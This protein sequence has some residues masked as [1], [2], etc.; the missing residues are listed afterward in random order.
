M[1]ND[2]PTFYD[3]H[4]MIILRQLETDEGCI[5]LLIYANFLPKTYKCD[6]CRKMMP[7]R[8]SGNFE[9]GHAYRCTESCRKS[10]SIRSF[11]CIPWPKTITLQAYVATVFVQF[12]Q[13]ITGGDLS[14]FLER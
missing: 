9:G 5:E 4:S 2:I 13:G 10:I 11:L 6:K 7:I 14:I 8:F 3:R 12:P 1:G